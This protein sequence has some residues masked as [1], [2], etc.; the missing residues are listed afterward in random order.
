MAEKHE[1][2][3]SALEW[4]PALARS[5]GSLISDRAAVLW[6]SH[7]RVRQAVG[8][9]VRGL[10]VVPQLPPDLLGV[11]VLQPVV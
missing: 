6:D 3:Q 7:R 9:K 1:L 8:R 4:W 11:L 2:I 10:D 5:L